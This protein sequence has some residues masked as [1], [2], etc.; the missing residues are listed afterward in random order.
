MFFTISLGAITATGH[1]QSGASVDDEVFI[2]LGHSITEIGDGP[3]V[4]QG[5]CVGHVRPVRRQASSFLLLEASV[6]HN[7]LLDD[8]RGV[9][10][11][12]D[13]GPAVLEVFDAVVVRSNPVRHDGG[14][15]GAKVGGGKRWSDSLVKLGIQTQEVRPDLIQS[16]GSSCRDIGRMA[17]RRDLTAG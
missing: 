4:L 11:H 6:R 1:V 9:C 15:S 5:V 10:S 16:F 7:L 12:G 17:A 3:H 2:F 14:I 8:I 13:C